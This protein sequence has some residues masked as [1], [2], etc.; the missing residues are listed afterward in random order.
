MHLQKN[1]RL[2]IYDFDHTLCFSDGVVLIISKE[3][4]EV[5]SR[6]SAME[7]TA[8][9]ESNMFDPVSQDFDFCV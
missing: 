3:T 5:T 7:Y 9:R 1:K 6:L 4:K 2:A 8:Y